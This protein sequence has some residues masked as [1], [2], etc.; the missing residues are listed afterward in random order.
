MK[1]PSVVHVEVRWYILVREYALNQYI[2]R[3]P[4][5]RGT[6]IF[7]IIFLF[8]KPRKDET[9]RNDKEVIVCP[10]KLCGMTL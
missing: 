5:W 3:T 6:T 9:T 4:N 7:K 2:Q 10:L 8:R 1:T